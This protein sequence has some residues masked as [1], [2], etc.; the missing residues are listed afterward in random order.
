MEGSGS[1]K[2]KEET[3]QANFKFIHQTLTLSKNGE[4]GVEVSFNIQG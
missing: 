2:V 3:K 1:L 4:D